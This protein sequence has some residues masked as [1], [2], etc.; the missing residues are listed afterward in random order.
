[1]YLTNI[2]ITFLWIWAVIFFYKTKSLIKK[3]DV[4]LSGSFGPQH[5]LWQVSFGCWVTWSISSW[6]EYYKSVFFTILLNFNFWIIKYTVIPKKT[7][8]A[9]AS[10]ILSFKNL[11]DWKVNSLLSFSGGGLNLRE[12]KAFI[13]QKIQAWQKKKFYYPS[14]SLGKRTPL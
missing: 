10:L 9:L 3:W 8:L 14:L 11:Q 1:M 7:Y 12:L 13:L 2:S 5:V 6:Q 4:V